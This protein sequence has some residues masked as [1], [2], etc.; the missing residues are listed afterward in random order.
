MI[1]CQQ[2][3][4]KAE[5]DG[6]VYSITD[7]KW[8]DNFGSKANYKISDVQS[9]PNDIKIEKVIPASGVLTLP[10]AVAI[11]TAHNREYQTQREAL[12]TMALDLTLFRHEFEPWFF[13][14]AGEGYGKA[15]SAG[16][17]RATQDGGGGIRTPVP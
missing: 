14:G 8:Q 15:G 5:A 4:Y 17:F 11:A 16:P 2:H 13:S 3:D 12:Y 6:A 10:Q 7:Q 9:S 1:G